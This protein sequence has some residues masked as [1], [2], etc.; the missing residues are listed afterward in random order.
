[1]RQ[2][3]V[4][5]YTAPLVSSSMELNTHARKVAMRA[6]GHARRERVPPL[7]PHHCKNFGIK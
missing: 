3:A 4:G 6:T 7:A 5:Y 2:Y 1:M